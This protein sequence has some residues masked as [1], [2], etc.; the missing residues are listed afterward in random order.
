MT[1]LH[2]LK[3]WLP[4]LRVLF[5]DD[6]GVLNDN[7]LREPEWRRI[8][9]EF[10]SPRLGGMPT[11]W[12][13]ANREVFPPLWSDLQKRIA[14]FVTHRE[15]QREYELLWIKRMCAFV[16]VEVP[17]DD[18]AIALV[19][20]AAVSIGEQVQAEIDGAADA[21]KTLRKAGY[22]LHMAS[23]TPSWELEAILSRMGIRQEFAELYGPDIIDHVKHGPDFYSRIFAHAVVAPSE[24]LVIESSQECCRRA[25]AA[26]AR[27][28]WVDCEQTDTPSLAQIASIVA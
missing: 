15:F 1:S 16:G 8:I 9:G 5:I 13:E 10:M 11:L 27:T 25:I 12:A 14:D 19:R 26:G 23:G 22:V 18:L 21:V 3:E 6:G 20:E 17:S 2:Q 4:T 7:R 24:C 28:V